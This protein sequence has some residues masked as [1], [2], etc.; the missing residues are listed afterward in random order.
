MP[1]PSSKF[2]LR[3]HAW[4][5]L[6]ALVG[7]GLYLVW[8]PPTADLANQQFR[9][10]AFARAPFAPWNNNWFGGHHTPGY[11]LLGPPLG[12]L[13]GPE[14]LGTTAVVAA[15]LLA[16][17]FTRRMVSSQPT[18]ES[19]EWA[20]SLLSVGLMTSLFGGRTAFLVGAAFLIASVSAASVG[21]VWSTGLLGALATASSPV[22]GLLLVL[23]GGAT[24]MSR[25]VSRSVAA[26]M[27]LPSVVLVGSLAVLFPDHGDF[28]FPIGGL[29]NALVVAAL[30]AAVGWR[31]PT[32]RWACAGYG[33]LCLLVAV[34]NTPVGGNAARLSALV[35]PAIILLSPPPRRW[36]TPVLLAP[37]FVLQWSPVSLAID[38]D[39]RQTDADFYRPLI[40]VLDALPHPM[41]AE[42]VPLVTH[43]EASMV[44]RH[45]PLARGWNRQLDRYYNPIFYGDPLDPAEYFTWLVDN[46]VSVVAIADAELDFAGDAE[47]TLLEDPPEYLELVFA[48]EVWRVFAVVPHPSLAGEGGTVTDL[49]VST[50]TVDVSSP[51]EVE[52]KVRYSPW[53]RVTA[54]D[55]CVREGA[56]GWTVVSAS[57]PGEIEVRAGVTWSSLV[58]R[59]GDC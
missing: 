49:D 7:C 52:V 17:V 44:G 53:F 20:A 36:L 29:V 28:P 46:G 48:D 33:A 5:L 24:W 10:W 25:A 1:S 59:D 42:V 12:W 21:R 56:D 2:E 19:P 45:T 6:T 27:I 40:D 30:I 32:V 11:S 35:A 34:V 43:A 38:T 8:R 55:A 41:R 47:A 51:G 9:A 54:G 3:P 16:S 37:L 14:I 39:S 50:F 58:D 22:A 57:S 18:L 26:A 15:T 13:V 31:F 4:P 23:I